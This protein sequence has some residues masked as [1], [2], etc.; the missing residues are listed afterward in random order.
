LLSELEIPRLQPWGTVNQGEWTRAPDSGPPSCVDT[1][2]A[3]E[4]RHSRRE[5]PFFA[6][7]AA[8]ASWSGTRF[9]R[10]RQSRS[11]SVA[12]PV[13][14]RHGNLRRQSRAGQQW[15]SSSRQ[16]P[17]A[18]TTAVLI[19]AGR[20][21]V[22][23]LSIPSHMLVRRRTAGCVA[24]S[25]TSLYTDGVTMTTTE[26]PVTYL[27]VMPPQLK[28]AA[29]TAAKQDTLPLAA[30]IRRALVQY[31]NGHSLSSPVAGVCGACGR[32]VSA[33]RCPF[34]GEQVSA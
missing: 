8:R 26:R 23:P 16:K 13:S 4:R 15:G 33:C 24:L 20:R 22:S 10:S 1:Q 5:T 9:T 29:E 6:R 14:G 18:V 12:P 27:L 25:P 32:P 3:R 28:A 11:A 34:A 31:L 30:F 21:I 7:C 17:P 2:R 19:F